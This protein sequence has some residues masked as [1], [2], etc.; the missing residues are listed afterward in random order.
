VSSLSQSGEA[1]FAAACELIE[2]G[3]AERVVAGA[4][5]PRDAIVERVLGPLLD[6]SG[7][8]ATARGQGAG[9]TL[10]VERSTARAEQG[11]LADVLGRFTGDLLPGQGLHGVP[12][13]EPGW[14]VRVVLGV[15][16]PELRQALD[17]SS[18]A[19]ALRVD[20]AVEHG[21]HE[22]LGAVALA[23]AAELLKAEKLDRVL[24]LSGSGCAFSASLLGPSE[25]E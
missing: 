15:A 19:S 22:A 2:L 5:A 1:A 21:Y 9:F 25:R 16:G 23:V 8:R 6:P 20:L 13:L 3:V 18:W 4:V 14:R 7:F 17:A 12:E 10:L 11:V 24:V